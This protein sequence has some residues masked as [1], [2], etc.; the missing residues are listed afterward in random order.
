MADVRSLLRNERAQRRIKH[1]Q[2]SYSATGTLECAVCHIPLKS[3]VE[4]WDKHL[5]STQ[6]AMRQERLRLSTSQRPN[7]SNR[8]ERAG[9]A[10]SREVSAGSKKRKADDGD[11]DSRKRTRPVVDVPGGFFD[12][13][14][15]ANN[16]NTKPVIEETNLP[17]E[18][19][20]VTKP[21]QG[22][23]RANGAPPNLA[24]INPLTNPTTQPSAAPID[25]NEWA[26]FERDVATPPPDPS[27]PTALT[28]AAT[29]TAAPM[30]AAELAAQSREQA[31]LQG[32][33]RREAEVEGEKEDAARALE[34]EFDE[35]EGLEE[36]VRRLREKREELRLRRAKEAN[37]RLEDGAKDEEGKRA[38]GV[39]EDEESEDEE[40]DDGWGAWGR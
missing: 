10:S 20:A 3:D 1:P 40:D 21:L 31:S 12:E 23:V 2:A 9:E 14:I 32:R 6:H 27:A 5:K 4:V 38:G 28:A 36:R 30:T 17:L 15:E 39:E 19:D 35:M 26:A 34:D 22:F 7:S 24:P 8:P 25:E 16:A 13:A 18:R 37:E 11:D 33:E 29:I